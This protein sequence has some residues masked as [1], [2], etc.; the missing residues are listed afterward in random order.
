MIKKFTTMFLM[1]LILA[2]AVP[3]MSISASAQT[4]YSG[5]ERRYNTQRTN[6]R[7][8]GGGYG[9]YGGRN[10]VTTYDRHRKAINLTVAT[11]AGAIIGA[12]IGGK[13]GALIGTA[14][15]LA[16]GAIITAKQKPRNPY[17]RRY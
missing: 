11:G 12:L 6:Q 17:N 5:R 7:Y 15:G 14:A 8:Y 1:A 3:M 4:R 13:K 9:N 2:A 10:E 16:G